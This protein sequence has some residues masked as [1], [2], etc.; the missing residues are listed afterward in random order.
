[1]SV[2]SVETVKLVKLFCRQRKLNLSTTDD[3]EV[4]N[5]DPESYR[6]K[7]GGKYG[8]K[9]SYHGKQLF[10]SPP[11]QMDFIKDVFLELQKKYAKGRF[12]ISVIRK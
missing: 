4:C 8:G 6:S 10:K 5:Y 2:H 9:K 12:I 1:M 3:S 11:S 7:Y